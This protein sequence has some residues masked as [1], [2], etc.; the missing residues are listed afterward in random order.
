MN[1]FLITY[2]YYDDFDTLMEEMI[3][4]NTEQ[5][6][7]DTFDAKYDASDVEFVDIEEGFQKL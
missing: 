1:F 2:R 3:Y 4:A 5:D 6:A 7:M